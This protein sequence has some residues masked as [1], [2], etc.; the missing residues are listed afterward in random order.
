MGIKSLDGETPVQFYCTS[1]TRKHPFVVQQIGKE[2]K[3]IDFFF[4]VMRKMRK[5]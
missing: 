1:L 5:I 3:Q 4:F 2:K